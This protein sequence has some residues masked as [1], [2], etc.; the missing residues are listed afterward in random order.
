LKTDRTVSKNK[1]EITIR[2]DEKGTD[3][4]IDTAIF[5][6][7]KYEYDQQIRQHDSKIQ[8]LKIGREFVW[9]INKIVITMAMRPYQD[10]SENTRA[11]YLYST[12]ARIYR[13]QP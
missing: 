2:D 1:P 9:N 11:K 6:E 5:G 4:L 3:L 10:H 8:K 13:Q 12:T 7:K